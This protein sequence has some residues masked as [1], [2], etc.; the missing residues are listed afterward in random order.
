VP[1]VLGVAAPRGVDKPAHEHGEQHEH[2]ETADQRR[3]HG[4]KHIGPRR[5][6]HPLRPNFPRRDVMREAPPAPAPWGRRTRPAG[7]APGGTRTGAA[8]EGEARPDGRAGRSNRAVN[9]LRHRGD[10]RGRNSSRSSPSLPAYVLQPCPLPS[11][12]VCGNQLD[13]SSIKPSSPPSR[14]PVSR[15]TQQLLCQLDSLQTAGILARDQSSGRIF[16]SFRDFPV[17]IFRR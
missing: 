2:D 16:R 8:W 15:K 14:N 13:D 6:P 10:A 9:H 3:V 7:S 12:S 4:V 1:V 17:V 5:G 11:S